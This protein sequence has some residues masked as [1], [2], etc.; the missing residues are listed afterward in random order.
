MSIGKNVFNITSNPFVDTGLAAISHLARLESFVD[1]TTE[2]FES[3]LEDMQQITDWNYRLTPFL[4]VFGNNG[5]LHQTS[6]PDRIK[7]SNTVEQFKKERYKTMLLSLLDQM[8]NPN[9]SAQLCECCGEGYCADMNLVYKELANKDLWN[10]DNKEHFIG[11]ESFP[12]IGS[13]G[14]NAQSLP[15]A[16][17][18]F[19]VCP[20]CLIAVQYLPLATRLIQGKLIAFENAH[21]PFVQDLIASVVEENIT[22]LNLSDGKTEIIG[23]QESTAVFL[24]WLSDRFSEIQRA[25]R[26]N[27]LSQD[28][29]LYIWLFS[30]TGADP[31]CTILNIPSNAMHFIW[32]AKQRGLDADI[33]TMFRYDSDKKNGD[34]KHPDNKLFSRL[35][36][37]R[38]YNG[39]YPKR[40][41]GGVSVEMY[42][43]YQTMLLEIPRD[44]LLKCQKLANAVLPIDEK[45]KHVWLSSDVYKDTSRLKIVKSEICEMVENGEFSIDDYLS[46]FPV[47]QLFPLKTYWHGFDIIRYFLAHTTDDIPKYDCVNKGD[48]MKIHPKIVE[49]STLYFNYFVE[50]KGLTRFKKEVL[51]EL[52][53]GTKLIAW[54]KSV[55][56]DLAENNE[57]FTPYDWDGFWEALCHDKN[58]KFV[59]YELVFQMRL[60]LSDLY[61]RRMRENI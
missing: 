11:R 1:M 59:G 48:S 22:R 18:M 49:A 55:L 44:V 17:R 4:M 8:H 41:Y 26:R 21:S 45:Q 33:L 6:V 58:G 52:R 16:S 14:S 23:K 25:K 38:D 60:V 27:L 43:L 35:I 24:G 40:T 61:G 50:N 56:C 20:K 31:D 19:S 15:A 30:N 13:I 37:K 2:D 34:M 12:L 7:K 32:E 5:L 54:L 51:D 53:Q 46:I 9:T 57:G 3:V 28:A 42:S 29:D 47:E 10:K 39:L 36:H